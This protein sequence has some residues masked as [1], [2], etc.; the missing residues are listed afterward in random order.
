MIAVLAALTY[1]AIQISVPNLIYA[2]A[3]GFS[4]W[5]RWLVKSRDS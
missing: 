2:G 1:F 4:I 5:V 3:V